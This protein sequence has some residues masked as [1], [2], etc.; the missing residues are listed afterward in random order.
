[1]RVIVIEATPS[2]QLIS[3]RPPTTLWRPAAKSSAGSATPISPHAWCIEQ[4]L[5]EEED[6]A[7]EL[8]DLFE[9]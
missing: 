1:M 5:K 8:T 6:H 9:A 7:D 3:G 4:I 2:M